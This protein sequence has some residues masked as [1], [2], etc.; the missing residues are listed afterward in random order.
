[1][2]SNHR[3]CAQRNE[4]RI[5]WL[6]SNFGGN[7][8]IGIEIGSAS[9]TEINTAASVN[10]IAKVLSRTARLEIWER[11]KYTYIY[12]YIHTKLF[13]FRYVNTARKKNKRKPRGLGR[14]LPATFC[15]KMN[16]T[17]VEIKKFADFWE[18]NDC[19]SNVGEHRHWHVTRTLTLKG[20]W[21]A[22][23]EQVP[24]VQKFRRNWPENSWKSLYINWRTYLSVGRYFGSIDGRWL[25]INV[26]SPSSVETVTFEKS[27]PR[28]ITRRARKWRW[29]FCSLKASRASRRRLRESFFVTFSASSIFCINVTKCL[30]TSNFQ[31]K[32]IHAPPRH[33]TF[34]STRWTFFFSFTFFSIFLFSLYFRFYRSKN[35]RADVGLFEFNF[36]LIEQFKSCGWRRCS[37]IRTFN[38]YFFFFF[39]FKSSKL[40]RL[41][42]NTRILT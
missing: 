42:F 26:S 27:P 18:V 4:T 38:F 12:I 34:N 10:Q 5:R 3:E 16:R 41:N 17:S 35:R 29:E 22:R 21:S 9:R 8:T 36:A 33:F 2:T 7:R 37:C 13:T 32:R 40:D 6:S 20:R 28:F 24:K 14:N 15:F 39:F 19:S 23:G 30:P 31:G 25:V 1:M 11:L